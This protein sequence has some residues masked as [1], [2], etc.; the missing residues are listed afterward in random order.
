MDK[1]D[2]ERALIESLKLQM[3]SLLQKKQAVDLG[4]EGLKQEIARQAMRQESLE[5]SLEESRRIAAGIEEKAHLSAAKILAEAEAL[6]AVKREKLSAIEQEIALLRAELEEKASGEPVP[7]KDDDNLHSTAQNSPDGISSPQHHNTDSYPNFSRV[8]ASRA[9]GDDNIYSMKLV[10]FVNA[11]HFVVFGGA[12]GP[13]HAHS[14]QVETE[15]DVPRGIGDT[16]E[17]SRVSQAVSAALGP[18]ENTILNQVHPFDLILPTTEN[19]AMYFFNRLDEYLAKLGLKLYQLSL[20]ETPTRGIQVNNHNLALD[21][22]IA[23]ELK[24]R[25]GN[26]AYQEAAAI[27]DPDFTDL[28]QRDK[29][30]ANNRKSLSK[31]PPIFAGSLRAPYSVRQYLLAAVLILFLSLLAYQHILWTPVEQRFPWGSDSWGHLFKA[32]MLYE[33]IQQ[34]NYYPQFTEYWYNGVQPFRYWAPLPYYALAGLRGLSGDIFTAGHLYIYLCALLGA[35]SWL[36]LSRRMGLWPAVMAALV[37]LLWQDNVRVAFSEGNLPRVLATALLPLLFALFLH[38]IT[39]RKSYGA[40]IAVILT[41]Q[42]TLLCHAMIAAVYCLS[43]ALFV[44]FLWVFQGCSVK[45]LARG[46]MVLAAGVLTSSWW[47]LPSLSG[48]I[49]GIDAQAVKQVVQFVPAHISLSPLC[50]FK[51]VETFYWGISLIMLLLSSLATWKSKPAWARSLTVC[52]IILLLITFPLFRAIYITLP[53]SHLLWPLRFSSFAALAVLA[54]GFTLEL[55]EKRQRWLQS[56]TVAACLLVV[57]LVFLLVD[58]LFSFRLLAHT[59]TR[60]FTIIQS[61]EFIKQEP[62]WRVATIDL[63]QLGSAPSFTFSEMAGLEQVFG[64][65]W[66]GAVTSRNIMLLNTGL[67]QQYYPFLFR[68]CVDLGATDLVVKEDVITDLEAFREAAKRAGYQ[69]RNKFADIS[70]WRSISRPYLVQKNPRCLVIGKYGG[71]IALQFPEVEMA[72]SSRID[73]CSLEKLEQYSM[74]ILSGANWHSKKQAEKLISDYALSGGK[75]FIEMAGMPPNVLAKQ[76]EFLGVY[77]EAV[78]IRQEIEVRG[79][80]TRVILPP[81][82]QQEG[83]WKAYVPMGL[84]KVE[85]EFSYYGNQAPILGYKML[86]GKKIWF[87]GANLSY[88]AYQSGQS[89]SARLLKK[90]LDLQTEYSGDTILPL[91][92]YEA[93]EE[94]FRMSYRL[95]QDAEVIVPISLLDGL[96]VKLDGRRIEAGNYENLLKLHLPAGTHR[97]EMSIEKTAIFTWGKYLSLFALLLVI[98]AL[99]WLKRAGDKE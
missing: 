12:T 46:L 90:I 15:V 23:A 80:D 60:P 25:D 32:E 43:L 82:W 84:D 81:V 31:P 56:S 5:R 59:G 20:W 74:L 26:A 75:V 6:V 73:D 63:S 2:R 1:T 87:L 8:A 39:R 10:G 93:S 88:H 52:G 83:E 44:F 94:G 30:A 67:E 55:E 28:D 9:S 16:I 85:L 70:V 34:G 96:V 97:L 77:G 50:R 86:K 64:W 14:W 66:Q 41:V 68:S 4:I 11:R 79:E 42:L 24:A 37:W 92:E 71:T 40:I 17:F 91:Q 13:V 21:K 3:D 18:Y 49:T 19:I 38:I 45:D 89:E 27:A 22:Q 36:L 51:N 29:E 78:S 53:L 54:S 98:A 57:L 47:L 48:G 33:Q 72:L 65:A 35:L 62:G 58:C 95:E 69:Q 99:V 7:Q 61:G 76:P